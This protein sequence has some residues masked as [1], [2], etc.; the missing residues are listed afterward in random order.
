MRP[1]GSNAPAVQ[2][3]ITL[4]EGEA[5]SRLFVTTLV[6]YLSRLER[7][8]RA[9]YGS[10]L[11]LASVFEAVAIGAIEP[12]LRDPGFRSAHERFASV[13]GIE[14][15]RGINAMS[16]AAATGI[17]RETVRRKLHRLADQGYIL[18]KQRGHF[19]VTPGRVQSADYQAA[20]A[21]GIR[22]TVRF[23]NECL[24]QGLVRWTPGPGS[25]MACDKGCDED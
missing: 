17:P 6:N 13:V 3:R 7:E 9:L 16:I 25:S 10:D 1:T 12:A 8:K 21:R 4:E 22:E 14:G 15:Q 11:D 19:V 18:E 23:M 2:G 5:V 20:F 24:E